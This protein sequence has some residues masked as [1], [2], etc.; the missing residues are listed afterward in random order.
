MPS[1]KYLIELSG[2]ERKILRDIVTK[3]K[4]LA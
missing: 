3:A 4:T 1:V 2:E